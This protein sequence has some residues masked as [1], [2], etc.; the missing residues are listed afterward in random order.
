MLRWIQDHQVLLY[1]LTGASVLLFV[2]TVFLMPAI[3]VRIP[4]DY[5]MHRR[6]PPGRW[7]S[8]GRFL[9]TSLLVAKNALGYVFII[10]GL[11]MLVLPGQGLLTLLIG[12]L[13]VDAPGKYRAEKWVIARPRILKA[14]N[15]LR[16]RHGRAPL[17]SST[18]ANVT[19]SGADHTDPTPA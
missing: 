14:I 17:Q 7:A 10:A 6:R 4:P 13:I 19:K 18:A 15:W 1:W 11:G 16:R 8:R 12:F 9:R 3:L 5:F 2:A